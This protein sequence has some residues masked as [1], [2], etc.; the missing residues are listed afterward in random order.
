MRETPDVDFF[1]RFR[2]D[3][4]L[5]VASAAA[6]ASAVV[7]GNG[8]IGKVSGPELKKLVNHV[9]LCEFAF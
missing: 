4:H 9:F 2:G 6:R 8:A 1:Y 5:G 3:G 7:V